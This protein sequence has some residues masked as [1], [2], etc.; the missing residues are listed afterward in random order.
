MRHHPLRLIS[1]SRCIRGESRPKTASFSS[2]RRD[3]PRRVRAGASFKCGILRAEYAPM[4]AVSDRSV[5]RPLAAYQHPETLTRREVQILRLV[6][7]GLGNRDIA[8]ALCVSEETV[9]THLRRLMRKLNATSR[10]NA[11]AIAIRSDLIV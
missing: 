7:D 2:L 8:A 4:G 6:A 1:R 10:A 5:R 3:A 11:V 9:K